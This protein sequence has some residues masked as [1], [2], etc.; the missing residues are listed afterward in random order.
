MEEALKKAR[1]VL[2][3]RR[4]QAGKGPIANIGPVAGRKGKPLE[5]KAAALMFF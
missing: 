5:A 3:A 1:E 2:K 4:V